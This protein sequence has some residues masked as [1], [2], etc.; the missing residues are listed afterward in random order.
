MRNIFYNE[1]Y[2]SELEQ[3]GYVKVPF[4]SSEEVSHLLNE[5][6]KLRP[7]D[8]FDPKGDDELKITFHTTVY[9]TN[10]VYKRKAIN[11]IKETFAPHIS[12]LLYGNEMLVSSFFVKQSG[13]GGLNPHQHSPV[14]SNVNDKAVIVWCPLI[15]VDEHNG[16]LQVIEGSHKIVP[17]LSVYGYPPFFMDYMETMKSLSKPIS[18]IAGEAIIFDNYLIHWST[19]NNTNSPRYTAQAQY[20]PSNAKPIFYYFD[21][22]NSNKGFERFEIDTNFFIENTMRDFWNNRPKN[23][24]SLGFLENRNRIFSESEFLEV[25][26]RGGEIKPEVHLRKEPAIK[27]TILNRIKETFFNSSTA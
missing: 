5:L 20:I 6:E 11:L 4:L 1:N 19:E 26:K 3:K 23:L 12:S 27:K 8:S 24:T 7:D 16:T 17:N 15:D 2:Q 21:Q 10:V 14:T 9:D 13:K 25:L 18:L 22:H